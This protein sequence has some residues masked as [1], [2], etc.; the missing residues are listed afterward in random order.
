MNTSDKRILK[1]IDLLKFQKT[2]SSLTDFY[3]EIGIQRQT[4]YK[5]KNG[6]AYFTVQHIEMICKKYKVNANW[7]FG[8][9][10]KVFNTPDSIEIN[11]I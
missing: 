7:I 3:E 5:I 8:L 11:D 1:L 9:D 4:V 6:S 2:I 10:S